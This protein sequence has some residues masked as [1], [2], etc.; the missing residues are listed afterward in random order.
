M[1]QLWI[2]P[3]PTA[4]LFADPPHSFF[5]GLPMYP[6]SGGDNAPRCGPQGQQPWTCP[7]TRPQAIVCSRPAVCGAGL[8]GPWQ[9]GGLWERIRGPGLSFPLCINS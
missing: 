6:G 8:V 2:G 7:P 1:P 4:A 9:A 3:E 5:P